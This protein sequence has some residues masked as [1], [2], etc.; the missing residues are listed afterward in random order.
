MQDM[1]QLR[2]FVAKVLFELA[3]FE[4]VGAVSFD[5]PVKSPGDSGDEA[6]LHF[7]VDQGAFNQKFAEHFSVWEAARPQSG[8]ADPT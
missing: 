2:D 5:V 4:I 7:S 6:T 1:Y 8:D 3:P